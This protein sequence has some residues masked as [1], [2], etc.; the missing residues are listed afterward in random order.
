MALLVWT[1][2]ISVQVKSMDDQHRTLV[3]L[4]NQLS[5][6]MRVGKGNDLL[7]PILASLI[8]YTKV[9]FAA[10]E[11]LMQMHKFPQFAPHKAAHEALTKQVLELQQKV[12]AGKAMLSVSLLNFLKDWLIN[13]IKGMDQEY[14]R[15][16]AGKGVAAS[17]GVG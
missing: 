9:H 5:D 12:E 8:K 4:V 6:A 1:N 11:R 2:E 13:H 16:I 14:G 17:V 15:F 7:V 10:E 3:D